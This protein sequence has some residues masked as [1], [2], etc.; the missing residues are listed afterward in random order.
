M[1]AEK[2]VEFIN[3]LVEEA[4]EGRVSIEQISKIIDDLRHMAASLGILEEVDIRLD[5]F[6]IDIA[7]AVAVNDI[8]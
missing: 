2:I 7:A 5:E 3:L 1:N 6:D 8:E 4:G